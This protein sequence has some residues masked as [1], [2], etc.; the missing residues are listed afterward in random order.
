MVEAGL[1]TK[2]QY[3]DGKDKLLDRITWY[4]S[5]TSDIANQVIEGTDGNKWDWSTYHFIDGIP[6]P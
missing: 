2:I 3:W 6:A 5:T 4:H 1:L